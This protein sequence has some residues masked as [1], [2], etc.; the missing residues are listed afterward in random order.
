MIDTSTI[1]GS[2]S[3]IRLLEVETTVPAEPL[4]VWRAWTSKEALQEWWA[5]PD[6]NIEL[7]IGGPFE[8]LMRTDLPAG[9]RGSEG[10]K[11]LSYVPGELL[12]FTWNAPPALPLRS[13]NTWV[14]VTFRPEGKGTRIRLVHTGFLTGADWDDYMAYF[15][16]AW[17]YVLNLLR[18]HWA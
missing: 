17:P 15:A 8:L 12:S 18:A 16:E 11:I 6:A 9:Y 10:C 7:R 2:G 3:D 13:S 1:P 5:V 14:V 4:E